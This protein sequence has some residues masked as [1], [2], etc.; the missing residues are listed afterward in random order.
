MKMICATLVMAMT[1]GA[2]QAQER[3]PEAAEWVTL[4][5]GESFA[6][7]RGVGLDSI[8]AGHWIIEDGTIRKVASGAVPTAADGQ[9]LEGGD[10]MTIDTYRNFELVLEWKVSAG[11]NSGI[12]YNVSEEMSTDSPPI[13]AALGF[14]YQILDDALHPDAQNGPNRMAAALYDLVPPA[15]NKPLHAVGSFNEARIIFND[16]HGEHWL[17][18]VKVVEFDLASA[19]FDSAFA[20]SKYHPIEGF[21]EQREGHI[22]L[23]DHGDDVW[24]RNIRIRELTP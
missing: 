22:V 1:L 15:P 4:F 5:D 17:N 3:Q 19:A 9:P 11:G 14:E 10:I 21:A 13:H 2:C 24:F 12:K 16:G 18:G 8:P 6:G 7:W 23:Q 20:V